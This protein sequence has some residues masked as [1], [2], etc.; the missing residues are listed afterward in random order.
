MNTLDNKLVTSGVSGL[1][2]QMGGGI[3]A[4][5]ILLLIADSGA[6]S[7]IFTKQFMYGGL[8]NGEEAFYFS[9]DHSIPEIR[10]DMDQF[11][12]N[13]DTYEREGKAEF[14][15]AYTPRFMNLLPMELKSKIS[16]R[17]FLKQ[18]FDPFN[19]LKT[20]ICQPRDSKYRGIIDSISYFLRAYDMNSVIE[21][22][23]LMSSI[24]KLNGSIHL[25]P[26]G[27][28]LH[29]DITINTMKYLADG[30]IEFYVKERGSMI[31]R[32]M[33]IRK[34]RG[35]IVPNKSINFE[36]TNGGIELETTS[37]VL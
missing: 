31:E 6:G 35:L 24:S 1:D 32:G 28:G 12:W 29:D 33:V 7:E 36:I 8:K 13:V 30:V 17:E 34:M 3:P 10:S 23:E 5:T 25:I 14:I 26:I 15:D 18:G 11:G 21:V 4:G 9:S 16:A 27:A 37:R 2:M 20:T 19:K 22:I